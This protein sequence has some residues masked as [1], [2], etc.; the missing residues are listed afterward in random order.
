LPVS[1]NT[2]AINSITNIVAPRNIELKCAAILDASVLMLLAV[3]LRTAIRTDPAANIVSS[4]PAMK[5]KLILAVLNHL[6]FGVT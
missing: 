3:E 1:T 6:L 2:T 5:T 4:V